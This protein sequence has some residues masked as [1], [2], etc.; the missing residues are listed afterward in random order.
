M[1]V[2]RHAPFNLHM[3]YPR[4]ASGQGLAEKAL[5]P[6]WHRMSNGLWTPS[7]KRSPLECTVSAGGGMAAALCLALKRGVFPE[8]RGLLAG[9]ILVLTVVVDR[10]LPACLTGAY[11]I[12]STTVSQFKAAME[13]PHMSD[14]ITIPMCV[15]FRFFHT[16]PG[17]GPPCSSA[18]RV[19][20][21]AHTRG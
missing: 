15:V 3:R 11:V 18:R 8:T 5:S 4:R 20:G 1:D 6:R 17:G 12:R 9:M 16:M 19:T 10:F 2:F 14:S 13:K 21:S 7:R